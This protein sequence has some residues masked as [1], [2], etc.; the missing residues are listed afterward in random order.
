MSMATKREW[1]IATCVL[2]GGAGVWIFFARAE[3]QR[4]TPP[5]GVDSLD[6]FAAVM[7]APFQVAVV[8]LGGKS[9]VVWIGGLARWSLPSGRACYVFDETGKLVMWDT[10]T[11]DAQPSTRFLQAARPDKGVTLDEAVRF[12]RKHRA[13]NPPHPQRGSPP[14]GAGR[15]K[16]VD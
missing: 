10:E 1:L 12:V 13:A 3:Q 16:M 7:P 14:G 11:G 9:Y 6:G 8:E 5:A 2:I 15:G 4:L